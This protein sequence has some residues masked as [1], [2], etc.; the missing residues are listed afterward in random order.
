MAMIPKYSD[1]GK[2]WYKGKEYEE[3]VVAKYPLVYPK[4]KL[5]MLKT[6]HEQMNSETEE[7]VE[8][9]FDDKIFAYCHTG[10]LCIEKYEKRLHT[11]TRWVESGI[12]KTDN[13]R[14][15]L[16]GN[17]EMWFLFSKLYLQWLDK[18]DPPYLYKYETGTSI[19]FCLPLENS[20]RCC[21]DF[22][23]F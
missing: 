1:G 14:I 3:W 17:Y 22:H 5:T 7:G 15:L 2:G 13:A 6:E 11:N 20:R 12:L 23:I 19:G 18:L 10:R 9:K 16:I 21:L 4:R 8:I